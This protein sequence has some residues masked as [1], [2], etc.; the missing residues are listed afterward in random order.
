MAQSTDRA[1]ATLASY[2]EPNLRSHESQITSH[3]LQFLIEKARLESGLS[4][5]PTPKIQFLI[6]KKRGFFD[7]IQREV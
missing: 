4:S 3:E 1:V 5:F 7:Q 2:P 6:E